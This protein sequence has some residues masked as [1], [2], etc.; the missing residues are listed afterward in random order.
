[1]Q[2][3][4]GGF[5]AWCTVGV[6]YMAYFAMVIHGDAGD[7]ASLHMESLNLFSGIDVMSKV[8][9]MS[10][11]FLR[12]DVKNAIAKAM[13]RKRELEQAVLYQH[14][15]E[16]VK[17]A[18]KPESSN[19][20]LNINDILNDEAGWETIK[21]EDTDHILTVVEVPIPY[22]EQETR[23]RRKAKVGGED[24]PSS[25]APRQ[26]GIMD[27]SVLFQQD[28]ETNK[29]HGLSVQYDSDPYD[30]DAGGEG[31]G[32]G[33]DPSLAGTVVDDDE[34]GAGTEDEA[35]EGRKLYS[36][37]E[38]INHQPFY[39]QQND[40]YP[41]VAVVRRL[42]T[43]EERPPR[44][45][46]PVISSEVQPYR[47]LVSK[48]GWKAFLAPA[49]KLWGEGSL[50]F[51]GD[52]DTRVHL[53]LNSDTWVLFDLQKSH[54]IT[55]FRVYPAWAN[56]PRV[57]IIQFAGRRS[58]PFY[59]AAE[60]VV[61]GND[62]GSYVAVRWSGKEMQGYR[63]EGLQSSKFF[64]AGVVPVGR[65]FRLF[66]KS[67]YTGPYG[68]AVEGGGVPEQVVITEVQFYGRETVLGLKGIDK[69]ACSYGY[70]Y[71]DIQAACKM[72]GT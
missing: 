18:S 52:L 30:D 13:E 8:K 5:R 4:L 63:N 28:A 24:E 16:V 55:G 35:V 67:A 41:R 65:Y 6:I 47:W 14:K 71:D 70:I 9:S 27:N 31:G 20:N 51:D 46:I 72:A 57:C 60:F 25:H 7:V 56:G 68:K 17:D 49:N 58:G 66:V 69:R 37:N 19:Q 2:F 59:D 53:K 21:A 48:E 29:K 42:P 40:L 23:R 36:K 64:D 33:L 54:S 26:L 50:L 15:A 22:R 38:I 45:A 10:R 61:D 62:G 39:P 43:L 32:R 11:G 34:E 44:I 1:M 3:N 12:E